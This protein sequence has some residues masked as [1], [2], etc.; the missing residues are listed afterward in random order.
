MGQWFD[1]RINR[2]GERINSRLGNW[3]RFQFNDLTQLRITTHY[4]GAGWDDRN[5][6]GNGS[7]R[8]DDYFTLWSRWKSDN[9][10]DFSYG[11]SGWIREEQ[12]AGGIY[13]VSPFINYSPAD[14]IN[15]DAQ[16][17]L[18]TRDN[19]LVWQQGTTFNTFKQKQMN[20]TVKS[21]WIIDNSQEVRLAMQWVGLTAQS[22][23]AYDINDTGDLY[24]S[25]EQHA[26]SFTQADL[27][28]Q[29]RYKYQF[30]PLSD[31]YVVYSRGGNTFEADHTDNRGIS[32]LL[33]NSFSDKN[34]DQLTMKVRYR[35]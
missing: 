31:L 24:Q 21:T 12:L 15:I 10:Q 5:S 33:S 4:T 23:H 8:T 2:S 29:L 3:M 27:A 26:D 18:K 34:A 17:Q 25:G 9:S 13:N 30:A 7:F 11:I 28:L 22:K 16:L 6:R 1:Y 19:W 32:D 20:L 14:N 35:F